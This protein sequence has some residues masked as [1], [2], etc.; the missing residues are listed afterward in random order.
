MTDVMKDQETVEVVEVVCEPPP[1]PKIS[2]LWLKDSRG[3]SSA[4][5]TF[6]TISFWVV[7]LAYLA[8]IV[9]KIGPVEFKA[10]DIGACAAYFGTCSALYF[11]RRFTEAK[12]SK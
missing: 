12:V 7:T 2:R 1:P 5:L 8:S 3:T 9:Q 11:G 10:F 4:S 6:A